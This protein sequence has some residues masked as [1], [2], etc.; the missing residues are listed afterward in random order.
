MSNVKK[1]QHIGLEAV[2]RPGELKR[3]PRPSSG[4]RNLSLTFAVSN[5]EPKVKEQ[6]LPKITE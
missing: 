3:S 6:R 5:K 1:G 4:G 2:G